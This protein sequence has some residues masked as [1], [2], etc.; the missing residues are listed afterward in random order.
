MAV[1]KLVFDWDHVDISANC[2]AEMEDKIIKMKHGKCRRDR[3]FTCAI[4]AASFGKVGIR[5]CKDGIQELQGEEYLASQFPP[6]PRN[7]EETDS[8]SKMLPLAHNC[9]S[10]RYHTGQWV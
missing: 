7:K 6:N 3:L 2:I 5:M 10:I 1:H 4:I 9:N 8:E